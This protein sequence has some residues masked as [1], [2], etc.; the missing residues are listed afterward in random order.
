[1]PAPTQLLTGFAKAARTTKPDPIRRLTLRDPDSRGLFVRINPAGARSWLAMARDPSGKQV[2]AALGD[3]MVMELSEAREKGR[4]AVQRI[5]AGEPVK[6][7]KAETK[8]PS[9][10]KEVAED[11]LERHVRAEGL[12]GGAE[13]ERQLNV[14]VYPE[15]ENEAFVEIRRDRL[16]ELLHKINDKKA[17]ER[18]NFGGKV[19]ADRV[20]A[21]LRKLFNWVEADAPHWARV[22]GKYIEYHSP[23]ARGM[24]KSRA[25]QRSRKRFL[26]DDEIRA[27]WAD[28]SEAGT[29]GAFLQTCLLTSQRRA[30]VL[31]MRWQDIS[32][33]GVWTVPASD[34]ILPGDTLEVIN[35]K[36]KAEER[37]KGNG[38]T[39][40]LPKLVLDIIRAQPVVAGN[41]YVFAGRGAGTVGNIGHDKAR[42]D[43]R[44][45][46]SE[47]WTIH[48]LRRTARTLMARAGVDSEHAE[49]ALGHAKAG[50]EGV[51]NRHDYPKEKAKALAKLAGLVKL[52]LSPPKGNVVQIGAAA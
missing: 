15:W 8:P 37:E 41:P 51:Y 16:S 43:E 27:L 17:G 48:D 45:P 11:F 30:K 5:K 38:G 42:I 39:L 31:S 7:P 19:M 2:W 22:N 21:T 34:P 6:E 49:L 12:A 4:E 9:T 35:R 47:P 33:D 20:L 13:V 26:K 32:K 46:T 44:V 50:S 28:W 1:M 29:F 18:G 14:Y 52:I 40:N 3:A 24:R 25:K 36:R 23:V 10:F